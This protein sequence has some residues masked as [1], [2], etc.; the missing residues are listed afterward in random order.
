MVVYFP[1]QLVSSIDSLR[2]KPQLVDRDG[3][4]YVDYCIVERVTK[5][6]RTFKKSN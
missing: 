1:I 4:L 6:N 3:H 2:L 5:R